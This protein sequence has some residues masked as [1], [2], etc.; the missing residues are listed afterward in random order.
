MV[1]EN[2]FRKLFHYL[3][4]FTIFFYDFFL[5]QVQLIQ[6][7]YYLQETAVLKFLHTSVDVLER[8][9]EILTIL[10]IGFHSN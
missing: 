9:T 4:K 10:L 2:Y 5:F 8:R 7:I 3:L 6:E 1:T